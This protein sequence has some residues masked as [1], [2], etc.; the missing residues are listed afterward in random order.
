MRDQDPAKTA[1]MDGS[2]PNRRLDILTRQLTGAAVDEPAVL[3]QD[4][5]S[6]L[7]GMCPKALQAV[8]VHDNDQLRYSIYEF[9]RVSVCAKLQQDKVCCA[10]RCIVLSSLRSS[11]RRQPAMPAYGSAPAWCGA[12]SGSQQLLP[13]KCA[14]NIE[15]SLAQQ[16]RLPAACTCRQVYPASVPHDQQLHIPY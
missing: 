16:L 15:D 2:G 8:L 5:Q 3:Q 12:G 7:D 1:S 11:N 6:G 9:L 13:V 4:G 14:L 10:R